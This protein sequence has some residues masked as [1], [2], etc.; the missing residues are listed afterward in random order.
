[1]LVKKYKSAYQ[2]CWHA[3]GSLAFILQYFG[4]IHEYLRS[5]SRNEIL[6]LFSEIECI[7]SKENILTHAG[8]AYSYIKLIRIEYDIT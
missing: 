7:Q 2:F 1:M 3:I 6:Y 8:Y 4:E 5:V